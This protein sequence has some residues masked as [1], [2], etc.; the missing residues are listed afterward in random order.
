MLNTALAKMHNGIIFHQEFIVI[1]SSG[2]YCHKIHSVGQ[3]YIFSLNEDDVSQI[4]FVS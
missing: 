4:I 1:K 2:I 3:S